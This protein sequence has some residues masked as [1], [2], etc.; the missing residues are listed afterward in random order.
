MSAVSSAMSG[1]Y[2]SSPATRR[3]TA[4]RIALEFSQRDRSSRDIASKTIPP[5]ETTHEVVAPDNEV[6]RHCA[7]EGAKRADKHAECQQ[8]TRSL[9]GLLMGADGAPLR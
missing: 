6:H 1:V 2:R 3:L 8:R 7:A 9:R 4:G 5:Y